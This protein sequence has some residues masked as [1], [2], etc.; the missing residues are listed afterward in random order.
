MHDSVQKCTRQ[1]GS[2]WS[3]VVSMWTC[4]KQHQTSTDNSCRVT[5]KLKN[6]KVQTAVVSF[7]QICRWK[8]PLF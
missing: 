4:C 6:G 7:G 3:A 1:V 2:I 5:K 8:V